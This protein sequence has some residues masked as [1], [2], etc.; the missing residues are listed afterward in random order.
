M[1]AKGSFSR[2]WALRVAAARSVEYEGA[3]TVEFLLADDGTFWF[4]EMNTRLQVEH[5]VTEWVS[6]LDLVR[7]QLEV[8]A[9]GELPPE[10]CEPE[11]RGHA[12]ECRVYAEDPEQGHL[13][14]AGPLLL[15]REP[16]GPGIRVDSALREGDEVTAAA[17]MREALSRFVVL[18][19]RT[20]VDHLADVVSHPAFLA[21]DT[22]T[23]FLEAH[24]PD[25]SRGAA[26]PVALAATALPAG[27]AAATRRDPG[28][29][30]VA[31]PWRSASGFRLGEP[32]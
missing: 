32:S 4:L 22:T 6:G 8:A 31:D 19:V 13:P 2:A 11:L 30:R 7:L 25:W 21:G 12:I 29:G 5:P 26:P 27:R 14:Q 3:G 9:G 17:R 24:L 1:R 16:F 15:V 23:A 10:A 28:E 18:G 20:N